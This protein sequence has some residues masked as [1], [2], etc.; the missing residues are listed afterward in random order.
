MRALS[1]GR[2]RGVRVQ[3]RCRLAHLL[4]RLLVAGAATEPT[5]SGNI[6]LA[7]D[8]V[9][10]PSQ[11]GTMSVSVQRDSCRNPATKRVSLG[12]RQLAERPVERLVSDRRF[13]GRSERRMQVVKRP[14]LWLRVGD[15]VR[16]QHERP[17]VAHVAVRLV[18][19]VAEGK[20]GHRTCCPRATATRARRTPLPSARRRSA[21]PCLG[22]WATAT[23][24]TT[25]SS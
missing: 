14:I 17:D 16:Q 11:Q 5:H 2:W 10:D 19:E 13:G 3:E 20:G 12:Q 9:F 22:L 1:R 18:M 15:R 25:V 6:D 4:E 24:A 23:S 7:A 21:E 8:E